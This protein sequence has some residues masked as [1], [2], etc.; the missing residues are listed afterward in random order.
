MTLRCLPRF[1]SPTQPE[2]SRRLRRAAHFYCF[3]LQVFIFRPH[4]LQMGEEN[5]DL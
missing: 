3:I 2:K 4:I 1:P 5:H